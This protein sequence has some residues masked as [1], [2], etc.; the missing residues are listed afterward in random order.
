MKG[1]KLKITKL[2]PMLLSSV[3]V[4]PAAMKGL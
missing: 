4:T 1:S 3:G 2:D